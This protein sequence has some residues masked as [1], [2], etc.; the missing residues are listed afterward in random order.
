MRHVLVGAA[1]AAVLGVPAASA[2]GQTAPAAGT[3]LGTITMPRAVLA[4][5][6]PLPAGTY[7]VRLTGD[8]AA[9]PVGAS[10]ERYVEFVR[11]GKTVGRE[12]ATVISGDA[13]GDVVDGPRPAAG[14]SR[15][16]LL[17]GNDY[18]RVWFSRGGMHYLVHLPVPSA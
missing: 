7:Q 15:V 4:D 14:G 17:K 16:E 18:M 11:G 13:I 6:K 8:E 5:G 3:V 1:M 10:P 2:W 12:L 9:P